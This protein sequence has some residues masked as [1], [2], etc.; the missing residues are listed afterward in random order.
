MI[1]I[2]LHWLFENSSMIFSFHSKKNYLSGSSLIVAPVSLFSFLEATRCIAFHFNHLH[3]CTVSILSQLSYHQEIN[4]NA[5]CSTRKLKLFKRQTLYIVFL[6]LI[7]ALLRLRSGRF[8]GA[9]R[10]RSGTL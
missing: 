4:W 3:V 8:A 1:P 6:P 7:Y 2:F 10:E 5:C 9:I